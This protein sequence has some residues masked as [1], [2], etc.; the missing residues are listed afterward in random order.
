LKKKSFQKLSKN[1]ENAPFLKMKILGKDFLIEKF[2]K[3]T[4]INGQFNYKIG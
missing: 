4:H 2:A 3:I 1:N